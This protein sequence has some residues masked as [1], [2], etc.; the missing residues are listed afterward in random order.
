MET[1]SGTVR[2]LD[3][4]TGLEYVRLEDP[5]QDPATFLEFGPDGTI[6]VSTSQQGEAIHVWDL[7]AIRRQL[8]DLDLDWDLPPY[9]P[10][11][12]TAA[13]RARKGNGPINLNPTAAR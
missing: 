8:A 9:P 6:L 12:K 10:A 5:D 13:P 7:R 3:P 2:L 11:Q 1:G 4:D